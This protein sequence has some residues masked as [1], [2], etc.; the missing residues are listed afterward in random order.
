[1]PTV[2]GNAGKFLL[3]RGIET[4]PSA[5]S[6]RLSASNRAWSAPNPRGCTKTDD[7][8]VL[9]A[10]LV[11]R[12]VAVDLHLHAVRQ[13]HRGRQRRRCCEKT[14]TKAGCGRP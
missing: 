13:R 1:M 2:S 11:D 10:G 3:A 4:D 9:A 12:Q 8:L 7:E 6:L 14:R 5:Y